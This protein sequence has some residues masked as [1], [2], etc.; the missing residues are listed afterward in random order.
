M[1]SMSKL[2]ALILALTLA[3]GMATVASAAE[4][5]TIKV[6]GTNGTTYTVIKMFG[7]EEVVEDKYIYTAEDDWTGFDAAAYAGHLLTID[8]GNKNVLLTKEIENAASF[9]ALA[10]KYADDKDLT[11]ALT[12]TAAPDGGT[13]AVDTDGY[14]LLMAEGGGISGVVHV[15]GGD[16]EVVNEKNAA[17]T[18]FPNLIKKVQEDSTGEYGDANSADIGQTIT[19]R[20]TI[21]IG[22]HATNYVMHDVMDSHLSF[23]G[24]TEVKLGET[25]ITADKY[26]VLTATTDPAVT[27]TCA[28]EVRFND[29]I[30]AGATAGTPLYVYYTA[31]LN[32][33]AAANTTYTNTAWLTHAAGQTPEDTTTTTTYAFKINKTRAD[34]SQ[35]LENVGFQMINSKSET[36]QMY[37]TTDGSYKVCQDTGCAGHTHVTEALTDANGAI[38][39]IGLDADTYTIHESTVLPGYVTPLTDATASINEGSPNIVVIDLTNTLGTALPETGG[40]GTTIFYVLGAALAVGA[41]VLLITKKRMGTVE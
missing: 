10:A 39:I 34:D 4:G 25:T 28:F 13:V 22:A 19:Y 20:V 9:A 30:F 24:V 18:N 7:S 1:K 23:I 36:I 15:T 14:Y 33:T 6:I 31:K 16:T 32:D 35:P 21:N 3:L 17:D 40:I 38:T 2:L 37:L 27:D 41:A 11:S 29:S 12:V 5:G 8:D 26:S